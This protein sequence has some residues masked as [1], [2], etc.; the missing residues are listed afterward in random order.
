MCL[1]LF[2]L[3]RHPDYPLIVAA[4]RDEFHDRPTA[5]A[6]FWPEAP[7]LLAGRDLQGGGTWLGVT[8]QGR[9]AA[10]TNFRDPP[11]HRDDAPSR[12][13]LVTDFLRGAMP[14]TA[15]LDDV[16]RRGAAYNGFNLVA[17]GAAALSAYCNRGG[18]VVT[19][20]AGV[21]GISNGLLDE[22]WPKV[23][24]GRAALA[25]LVDGG[26]PTS[27]ALFA[28]LADTAPAPDGQLPETGI[29]LEW[30]RRLSP[31]FIVSP[32][33]GTRCSTVLLFRRD[34][35][36][37]FAERAFDRD[38]CPGETVAFCFSVDPISDQG[39]EDAVPE[40]PLSQ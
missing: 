4:N 28:L 29:G 21:H 1:I 7:Q 5:A 34:G 23:A 19:L 11:S 27:E 25:A 40:P 36:V 6:R 20:G 33:Y 13:G 3:H 12:G 32:G 39:E 22:A 15:Y 26:R 35:K 10:L 31:R 37:Y 8:R 38:G 18:G 24:A 14:A 30:E 16:A 9:F 17:G 2:A